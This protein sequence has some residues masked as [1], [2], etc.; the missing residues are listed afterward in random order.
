[1]LSHDAGWYH[2]GEENGGEY[3]GYTTLFKKLLPLLKNEKFSKNEIFQ[4]MVSN[5][6]KAFTIKI[7]RLK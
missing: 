5:P 1:L 4:I 2:S 7:R 6:A 3:R